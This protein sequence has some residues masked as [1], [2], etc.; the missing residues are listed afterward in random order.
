MKGEES[1]HRASGQPEEEGWC[2]QCVRIP[3]GPRLKVRSNEC[4]TGIPFSLPSRNSHRPAKRSQ[5]K[6]CAH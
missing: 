4:F 6:T 3:T 2:S 5:I 1:V